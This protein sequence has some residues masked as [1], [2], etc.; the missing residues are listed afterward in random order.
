MCPCHGPLLSYRM[1]YRGVIL[2]CCAS[3]CSI[4][5]QIKKYATKAS[6][7]L[8]E[9]KHPMQTAAQ[10]HALPLRMCLFFCAFFCPY[11]RCLA[12]SDDI[13]GFPQ[14]FPYEFIECRAPALKRNASF[15][16]LPYPHADP[17]H[18]IRSGRKTIEKTS[19]QK[20]CNK[21][22]KIMEDFSAPHLYNQ[23][24]NRTYKHTLPVSEPFRGRGDPDRKTQ[25]YPVYDLSRHG[26]A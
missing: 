9:P 21:H 1:I 16:V 8:P 24:N 10:A 25:L 6:S 26:K 2:F 15:S 23:A 13:A 14:G 12:E 4:I 20:K 11:S 3:L 5:C 22:K 7:S 17:A 19:N 18:P